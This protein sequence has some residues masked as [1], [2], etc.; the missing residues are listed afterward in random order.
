VGLLV[1]GTAVGAVGNLVGRSVGFGVGG[2]VKTRGINFGDGLRVGLAL[3]KEVGRVVGRAV[4]TRGPKM[5]VRLNF[6]GAG[7]V[8]GSE[9]VGAKKNEVGLAVGDRQTAT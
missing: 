4:G 5:L 2:G 7:V 8:A 6:V 3:G 1:G 9:V